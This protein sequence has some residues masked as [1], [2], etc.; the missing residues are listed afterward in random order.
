[1]LSIL[2]DLRKKHEKTVVF[3]QWTSMLSIIEKAFDND[4]ISYVRI[5]GTMN[6]K[7]RECAINK[8][9]E[10]GVEVLLA[11]LRSSGVGLNLTMASSLIL[12]DPWWNSSVIA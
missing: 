7:Q 8:F 11:T 3:S 5:D 4:G 1:M 6:P 9:K 10:Q 2:R 12:V